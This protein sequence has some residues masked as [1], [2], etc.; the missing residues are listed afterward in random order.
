MENLVGISCINWTLSASEIRHETNKLIDK[1]RSVYDEIGSL[2]TAEVSF[3]N[4][5]KY[6][7]DH[8]AYHCTI[9][10][11]VEFLQHVSP[12][13][14]IREASTQSDKK[15]SG[16]LIE[17]SMREDV[18]NNL[19]FLQKNKKET[20]KDA[21]S[22]R[23]LERLIKVGRRN[24]VHL[25]QELRHQL[26]EIKKT[27]GE[28][29]IDFGKNLNDDNTILEFFENDLT[30]LPSE[31]VESLEKNENGARKITL[32]YPHY[33]PVMRKCSNPK[34]RQ[35]IEKVFNSRCLKENTEI[36]E[37][38]VDLRQKMATILG[39]STH[40]S[41]ILEMRM[42]KTPETVADFLSDLTRKL[43][44]LGE[45]DLKTMLDLKHK[46]CKELGFDF[47]GKINGW[48][49]RYY[50]N[51][52]EEIKYA[53]DQSKIKEYFP[54]SFVTNGLLSIYQELLGLKFE[55]IKNPP[56]W[57]DEV[58]MFSVK[59]SECGELLGYFYLDLFPREGKFGH[60]ACFP[61]QPGCRLADGSRQLAVAV[62][63]ANFTK[64]SSDR[65]S[66][67]MHTEV[68]TY[69][70]EFGHVM[71]SL[72][73]KVNYP[74]FSGLN[75]ERDFVEAPSQMLE[76][77][78]WEKEPLRRMSSHFKDST[79]LPEEMLD[80]LIKSR[81]ANVGVSN[82]RQ[83]L[84]GSFDQAIHTRGKA[85]TANI[86]AKLSQEI[87]QVAATPGTNM[88][89]SFG[90][91]TGGYDAQ[92]YGYLWSEVYCMDMYHSRFKKEGIMNAKVG[93]EYRRCILEPGGSLDAM[94]MLQNFL[95]RKPNN[96]AFLKSKGLNVDV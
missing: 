29:C 55:E 9:Q 77:W 39:Y 89:A 58:R 50:M 18:F 3:E 74:I 24:G 7:G 81:Y 43:R 21:E 61:I 56:V 79:P 28:L 32:E 59:D 16:F 37:Q 36:L 45:D 66:L 42:A 51:K 67:L 2:T 22:V 65:P 19:V 12:D 8:M 49:L 10:N 64:P 54:M 46:E 91:L 69:F 17:M 27:T 78:C 13:S 6:L 35:A 53:V 20:L 34:I 92:Y 38:L 68:E 60:A 76:N 44:S 88:A 47:D 40:S 11:I 41:Y 48:D 30:G 90:H 73:I 26:K 93:K 63:V 72:C 57:C 31:F 4:T 71:H 23:Y 52:I 5:I 82:L 86:M 70:H 96:K 33:F 25:C 95:G 94:D 14:Y 62:M 84:L 1:T 85:D 15:I 87:L 75:V 83:I 80:T